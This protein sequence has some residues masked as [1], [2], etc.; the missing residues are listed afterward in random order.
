MEATD[1]TI[2]EIEGHEVIMAGSNNYLGLTNDQRTIEA[3]QAALKSM[4]QVVRVLDI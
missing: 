4:V 1:G 2:V 3:A